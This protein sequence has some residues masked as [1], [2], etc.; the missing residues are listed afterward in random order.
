MKNNQHHE[1]QIITMKNKLSYENNNHH[2]EKH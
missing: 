2:Y 1:K